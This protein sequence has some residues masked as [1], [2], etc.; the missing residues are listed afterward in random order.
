MKPIS[1]NDEIYLTEEQR[2]GT[3]DNWPVKIATVEPIALS[4]SGFVYS[5][6]DD[7]VRCIFCN[8]E[9]D[10]WEEGDIP[11]EEHEKQSPACPI[12]KIENGECDG[13]G[14]IFRFKNLFTALMYMPVILKD[15][16]LPYFR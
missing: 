10:E 3:F 4:M 13:E 14:I 2:K 1:K 9:L 5:G 7:L 12:I 16:N 15:G 6:A 8:C 11:K